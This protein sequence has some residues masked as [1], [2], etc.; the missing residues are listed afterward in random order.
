MCPF[1]YT[2][3]RLVGRLGNRNRFNHT[4]RI[5]VT[6]TDSPKSVRNRCV[7]EV[8]DCVFVLSIV[9]EFYVGIGASLI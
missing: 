9:F 3:L 2:A 5:T 6:P 7:I 8:F 1:D 4:S